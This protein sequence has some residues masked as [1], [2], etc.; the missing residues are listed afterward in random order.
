MAAVL[1][2][3][4]KTLRRVRKIQGLTLDDVTTMTGVHPLALSN[5]E[6][7]KTSPRPST[8]KRIEAG[9]GWS[10]GSFYRLAEAVDADDAVLRRLVEGFSGTESPPTVRAVRTTPT[11][12]LQAYAENYI[13]S[14]DDAISRLPAVSTTRFGSSVQSVVRQC[15]KGALL[16]ASSWQMASMGERDG[17]GRLFDTV[18]DFEARRQGLLAR[19]PDSVAARFDAAC[20]RSGFSD[21]LIGAL[22]E[23][24]A[25]QV[26]QIRCGGMV[27]ENF[28]PRIAAFI[29]SV[30]PESAQQG[31]VGDGCGDS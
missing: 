7:G 12:V 19:V 13:G 22:L 18:R 1:K 26:W 8:V 9:L 25:E 4:G 21:V 10:D 11:G 27:P 28:R 23:L 15:G 3:A 6:R 29:K 31:G 30:D 16:A 20:L 24:T 2:D 17:A 14:V 5:I